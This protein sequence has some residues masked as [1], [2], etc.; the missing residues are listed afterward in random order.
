MNSKRLTDAAAPSM[1]RRRCLIALA[2]LMLAPRAFATS[3]ATSPERVV[4]LDWGLVQTLLALG[5]APIASAENE[6]YRDSVR[7][8][9]LPA[10]VQELGLRSEPNLELLQQLQPDLIMVGSDQGVLQPRLNAIAPTEIFADTAETGSPAERVAR[11]TRDVATRIGRVV[12]AERYLASAWHTF[13]LARARC[14]PLRIAPLQVISVIDER[15]ALVF[16]QGSLF[17]D[18]LTR[19]G[20]SNA[21]TT[22]TNGWGYATIGFEQL[23]EQPQAQLAYFNATPGL[24]ARLAN[25]PLWRNLPSVRSG[26]AIKLPEVLFYGGMPSAVSFAQLLA[27]RLPEISRV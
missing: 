15:R 19:L 12:A 5:L 26:R 10:S 18:V 7:E 2:A 20:L 8:P 17:D 27:D 21:W 13:D 23:A 25:N 24:E 4:A 6:L 3:P 9:K 11:L 16:G 22:A 14:A 1:D